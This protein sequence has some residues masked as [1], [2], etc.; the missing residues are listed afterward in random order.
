MMEAK[1]M[2]KKMET[3]IVNAI[4]H[5]FTQIASDLEEGC[6]EMG[7]HMTLEVALEGCIDADR[8][9]TFGQDPEAAKA[10]YALGSYKEMCVLG[11]KALKQYF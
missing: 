2:D 7:E 11:R 9:A 4:S 10:L 8:V 5:T 6:A 3:R 1:K